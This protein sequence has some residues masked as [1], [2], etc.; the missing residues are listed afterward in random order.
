MTDLTVYS[1]QNI[2]L[3]LINS[4]NLPFMHALIKE[5]LLLKSNKVIFKKKPLKKLTIVCDMFLKLK[6]EEIH[7]S[8]IKCFTIQ[9]KSA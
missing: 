7:G 4:K 1:L 8:L 6:S 5:R 9:A 3:V 2:K